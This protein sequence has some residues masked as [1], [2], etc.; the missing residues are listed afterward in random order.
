MILADTSVWV[1]H[2][3]KKDTELYQQLR[4]NNI[5]IHPF[6]VTE[7]VLGNLPDREKTIASL[8]RLPMVKVAQLSEVRRMIAARSLHQRS[9]GFVD[10]HLLAS[11][12]ITAHTVFWTRDKQLRTIA[13]T[14]GLGAHLT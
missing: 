12:L 11:A 1:E 14:L 7:L 8:D 5:Y 10:A 13:D 6:V 9:I 4:S 3:R 2:F